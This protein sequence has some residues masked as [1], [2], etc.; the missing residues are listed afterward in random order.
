[1]AQTR[2]LGTH[3]QRAYRPKAPRFSPYRNGQITPT[4]LVALSPRLLKLMP[5]GCCRVQPEPNACPSRNLGREE[6]VS[7][8]VNCSRHAAI[9]QWRLHCYDCYDCHAQTPVTASLPVAPGSQILPS[10]D[11]FRPTLI[12]SVVDHRDVGSPHRAHQQLR[13]LR[14]VLLRQSLENG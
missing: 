12:S 10:L 3:N 11:L 9:R 8:T 14:P 2:R 5:V 1:M 7:S 6:W 4:D 13:S